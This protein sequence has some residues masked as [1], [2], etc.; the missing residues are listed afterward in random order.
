MSTLL[1]LLVVIAVLVL[2]LRMLLRVLGRKPIV[3]SLKLLFIILSSYGF[4]WILAFAAQKDTI[5]PNATDVCFDDWCATVLKAERAAKLGPLMASGNFYILHVRMSN[6]A[7]GIAQQPSEPRIHILDKQG[8]IW[9]FSPEGQKA[10]EKETQLVFDIPAGTQG[11]VA[12]IEEGP[13]ITRF[14]LPENRPLFEL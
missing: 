9:S 13:S 11:L 6:H 4:L 7:R 1:F 8:H 14:L 5:V 12:L 10:L 3:P 2:L